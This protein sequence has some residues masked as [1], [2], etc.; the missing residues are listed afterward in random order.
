MRDFFWYAVYIGAVALPFLTALVIAG[1]FVFIRSWSH[2]SKKN[3]GIMAVLGALG[4]LAP[5]LAAAFREFV[6][7]LGR[8]KRRKLVGEDDMARGVYHQPC[9]S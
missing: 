5:Y 6:K 3:L 8:K 7:W 1:I 4:L 9:K 2:M